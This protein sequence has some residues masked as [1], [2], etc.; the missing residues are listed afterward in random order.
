VVQDHLH[1]GFLTLLWVGVGFSFTADS[2]GFDLAASRQAVPAATM[3]FGLVAFAALGSAMMVDALRPPIM[4]SQTS[5][6]TAISS[7]VALA[8]LSTLSPASAD[9]P[10]AMVD[11]DISQ[12]R[13][14]PG[15][16][17]CADIKLGTGPEVVE[18]SKV[19]LQWILRR[20]NGYYVDGSIKML[21][22]QSGAVAK[23][24]GSN[25]DEE[26]NFVFTIGDG[27]AISGVDQG[28]RGMRQGGTRR[29]VLPVKAAYVRG[30]AMGI[31][32]SALAM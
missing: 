19:S 29:L 16:G 21:S 20:S 32:P 22:A 28:V 24:G 1:L 8:A 26:N 3:R 4:S 9:S 18:G 25:F 15:G 7:G 5:R 13:K 11:I 27:S 12:F 23:A 30:V 2:P 10:P 14:I 6:R 17:Q 31:E